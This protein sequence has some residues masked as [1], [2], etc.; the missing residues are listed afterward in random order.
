MNTIINNSK[1]I[2]KQIILN[3]SFFLRNKKEMILLVIP[4]SLSI[5]LPMTFFPMSKSFSI[6]IQTG[7]IIPVGITFVFLSYNIRNSTI[8][9]NLKSTKN[10]KYNFYIS[11]YITMIILS[12][13]FLFLLLILLTI[14]S[15]LKILE[16]DWLSINKEYKYQLF[17]KNISLLIISN[18]EMVTIIFMLLFF[19]SHIFKTKNVL[20]TILFTLMILNII[21]GSSLNGYI[22]ASGN[23][24]LHIYYLRYTKLLFPNWMF[25]PSL[26]Y[27]FYSSGQLLISYGVESLHNPAYYDWWQF[28]NPLQWQSLK[29]L[30]FLSD[31]KN[32]W[33][34]NAILVMPGI[35]ILFYG[36]LG[37]LTSKF[38]KI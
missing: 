8:Y 28:T 17:N 23:D 22:W 20:Y 5:F 26:M 30:Y 13:I 15:Q 9:S 6:I 35:Q 19:V 2:A 1:L 25:Y 18:V 31:G 34:W 36:M 37:F 24:D 38:K 33:Q 4:I 11:I 14:F 32:I 12:F 10:N 7:V 29:N 16:T 3:Y 27:P 21:F